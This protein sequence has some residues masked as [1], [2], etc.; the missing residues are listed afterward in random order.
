[1]IVSGEIEGDTFRGRD[2]LDQLRKA[3]LASPGIVDVRADDYQSE[4]RHVELQPNLDKAGNLVKGEPVFGARLT[5]EYTAFH[6]VCRYLPDG[7]LDPDF[8]LNGQP[9]VVANQQ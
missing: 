2:I 3:L 6:V 8:G 1:M 7:K 5:K 9:L 4:M